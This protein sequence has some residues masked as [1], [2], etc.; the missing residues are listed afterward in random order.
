MTNDEGRVIIAIPDRG[1]YEVVLDEDTLPEGIEL[2][3]PDDVQITDPGPVRRPEPRSLP[4]RGRRRSSR[5]PS[6]TAS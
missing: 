3:D 4:D 1:A 5:C 6:P 2:S